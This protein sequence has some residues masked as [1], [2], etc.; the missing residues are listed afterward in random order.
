MFALLHVMVCIF[1]VC[2]LLSAVMLSTA[3][4]NTVR[5]FLASFTSINKSSRFGVVHKLLCE[6]S[7]F[8][9]LELLFIRNHFYILELFTR[10]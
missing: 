1:D 4:R 8:V 6:K 2:C 3:V 9:F 10:A 5:V 7:F